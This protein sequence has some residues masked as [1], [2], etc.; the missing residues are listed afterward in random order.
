LNFTIGYVIS[1]G[2]KPVVQMSSVLDY[3]SDVVTSWRLKLDEAQA[4]YL[5]AAASF[6]QLLDDDSPADATNRLALTQAR[7]AETQALDEYRRML[8]IFAEL[9]L[10]GKLPAER[11][12][13]GRLVSI[14]D[15][16]E[17]IRESVECCLRSSGYRVRSFPSAQTF[18]DSDALPQ[19][20][21][22]ILDVRI[23]GMDGLA[24]LRRLRA[25]GH[26]LPVIFISSHDSARNRQRA[27]LDGAF[28][29]FSKPFNSNDFIQ[30]VCSALAS[31]SK[32]EPEHPDRQS[33]TDDLTRRPA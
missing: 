21:C 26:R 22:L 17:S 33:A 4:Q 27:A 18:L 31:C 29:F 15:D 6:K 23:P 28:H 11:L 10:E 9:T 5:A 16:D 1:E 7:E 25:V 14:V 24:L 3:H 30:A 19:T 2:G 12:S 13:T 32:P 20:E 8:A